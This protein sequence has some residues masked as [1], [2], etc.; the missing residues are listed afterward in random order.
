[1][2]PAIKPRIQET[3]KLLL[4]PADIKEISSINEEMLSMNVDPFLQQFMSV[5][6]RVVVLMLP[7][8]HGPPAT[9]S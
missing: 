4:M 2:T 9:L 3:K 1:M 5:A 8:H 6:L 7:W